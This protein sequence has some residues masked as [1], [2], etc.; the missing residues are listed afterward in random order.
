MSHHIRTIIETDDISYDEQPINELTSLFSQK[1]FQ[2]YS[3]LTLKTALWRQIGHRIKMFVM[4]FDNIKRNMVHL[5]AGFI[6]VFHKMKELCCISHN[7]LKNEVNIFFNAIQKH[8]KYFDDALWTKWF[9]HDTKFKDCVFFITRILMPTGN[10][11]NEDEQNR[12]KNAVKYLN[13]T[14]DDEDVFS[15]DGK[16]NRRKY[17]GNHRVND[18]DIKRIRVTESKPGVF[19]KQSRKISRRLLI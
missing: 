15:S 18:H 17:E 3:E 16:T 8:V 7:V 14:N 5:T 1:D 11:L 12:I 4:V 9:S 2:S 19:I 13:K 6:L 10:I